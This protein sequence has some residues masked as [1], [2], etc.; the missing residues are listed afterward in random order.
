MVWLVTIRDQCPF[1]AC[2]IVLQ[3][4]TIPAAEIFLCVAQSLNCTE[5]HVPNISLADGIIDGLVKE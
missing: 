4:G 2:K 3:Y 1:I 5:I